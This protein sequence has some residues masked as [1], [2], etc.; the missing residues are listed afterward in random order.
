MSRF[1]RLR[2][3]MTQTGKTR[4]AIYEGMAEGSF[5]KCFKIGDRAAAWLES[6]IEGWKREKLHAAGKELA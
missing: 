5:P 1:I 2:E 6:E 4:S 3:V